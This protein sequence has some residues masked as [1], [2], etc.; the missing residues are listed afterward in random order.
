MPWWFLGHVAN[1][2][3]ING[4]FRQD[5]APAHRAKATQECKADFPDVITSAEWLPYSPD[6]NPV[7]YSIWQILETRTCAK[8]HKN[9]EAPKQSLQREWDTVSAEELRRTRPK[10]YGRVWRCVLKQK[11]DSSKQIKYVIHKI[12][13]YCYPLAFLLLN[14]F[15]KMKYHHFFWVILNCQIVLNYVASP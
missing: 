1:L 2:A 9:L 3:D 7:D 15:C 6:L 8:R 14:K 13:C 12:V 5:S 4:H 11:A 10:I